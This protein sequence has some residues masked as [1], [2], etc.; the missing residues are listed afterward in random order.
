MALD[1][2]SAVLDIGGKLIDRLW[3][4]PTQR[5]AAKLELLKLQQQGDLAQI[6]GQLEINKAEAGSTS[7]FVAGWRPFIGWVCGAALAYTYIGYPLILWAGAL[8]FPGIKP[9]V[10]GNDGMLYELMFGMLG[11]GGLRTFEKV[12]GV[13]T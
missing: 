10:L 3:P 5:D 2:I 9:P 7:T 6:A 4:D 8:W 13:A 11:L 1:P 12:K